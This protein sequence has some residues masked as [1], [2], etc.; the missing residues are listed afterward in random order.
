VD[1]GAGHGVASSADQYH[2]GMADSF[3]F[4]LW[5]FGRAGIP[6]TKVAGPH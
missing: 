6:T 5:Q 3:S 4:L 1:Y 2:E